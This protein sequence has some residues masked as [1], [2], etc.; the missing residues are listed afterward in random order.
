MTANDSKSYISY[1][2]KLVDHFSNTHHH[3]INK[4]LINTD[5]STLTEKIEMN[6]KDPK[7]KV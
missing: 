3:F 1:L 4:K 6:P 5:Y 7:F 2:N